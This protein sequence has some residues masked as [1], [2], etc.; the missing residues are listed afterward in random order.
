MGKT[1]ITNTMIECSYET[2]IKVLNKEII[3]WYHGA[4]LDM[5]SK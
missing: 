2:A 3:E 5:D 1:K 4:L